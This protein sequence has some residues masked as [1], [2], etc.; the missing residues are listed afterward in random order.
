[1]YHKYDAC[2]KNNIYSLEFKC[3]ICTLKHEIFTRKDDKTFNFLIEMQYY[4]LN[5]FTK[6]VHIV[7]DLHN[8]KSNFL[9]L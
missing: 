6:G 3:A 5:N 7:L 4:Y 9:R 1:M 8:Y 2:S